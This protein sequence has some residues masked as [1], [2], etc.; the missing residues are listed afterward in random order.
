MCPYD[1]MA[2]GFVIQRSVDFDSRKLHHIRKKIIF[3]I[4]QGTG[5]LPYSQ[6][7]FHLSQSII[8]PASG[9]SFSN[10]VVYKQHQC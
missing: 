5:V 4:Y 6:V 2:V 8:T 7:G 9:C 10:R 3:R 1:W